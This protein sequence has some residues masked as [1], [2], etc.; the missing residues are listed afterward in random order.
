MEPTPVALNILLINTG[1]I[2]NHKK[3]NDPNYPQNPPIAATP[4]PSDKQSI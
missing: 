2:P 1:Y 4:I 3:A